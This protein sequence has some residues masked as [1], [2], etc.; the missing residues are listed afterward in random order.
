LFAVSDSHHA[1]ACLSTT[2]FSTRLLRYAERDNFIK[3]QLQFQS[4]TFAATLT[5]AAKPARFFAQQTK[6][7]ARQLNLWTSF[8]FRCK[9]RR[10]RLSAQTLSFK[11]KFQDAKRE[12]FK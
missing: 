2:I 8:G 9:F 3:S 4:K 10:A 5:L 6:R 7:E 1:F 11:R 12:K